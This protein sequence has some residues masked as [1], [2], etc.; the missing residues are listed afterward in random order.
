M[1]T[2]Q[3]E[4]ES[5]EVSDSSTISTLEESR[6]L[7]D[8]HNP[9]S[10]SDPLAEIQG[11]EETIDD[12]DYPLLK[13]E[14]EDYRIPPGFKPKID[15]DTT[16][17][18]S[19][20]YD[21]NRGV[22]IR[23]KDKALG[24]ELD[25][26]VQV[27]VLEY[28]EDQPDVHQNCVDKNKTD[29]MF[30]HIM[31]KLT[32][33][34]CKIN[35]HQSDTSK[36]ISEHMDQVKGALVENKAEVRSLLEETQRKIEHSHTQILS[37]LESHKTSVDNEL[38]AIN[39]NVDR[40][41]SNLTTDLEAHRSEV[42]KEFER[43]SA[44]FATDLNDHRAVVNKVLED[45][46]RTH[47]SNEELQANIIGTHNM[48]SNQIMTNN[49]YVQACMAEM[50]RKWA[51]RLDNLEKQWEDKLTQVKKET[52]LVKPSNAHNSICSE[53]EIPRKNL[54]NISNPQFEL[55]SF[56]PSSESTPMGG[57]PQKSQPQIVSQDVRNKN[58]KGTPKAINKGYT[59]CDNNSGSD[60]QSK[61]RN[62]QWIE[63]E[64]RHVN[65][66][67]PPPP[68]TNLPLQHNPN[69]PIQTLPQQNLQ[70][71]QNV[72]RAIN[73]GRPQQ[74]FAI[75]EGTTK[76][77]T[78]GGE[79]GENWPVFRAFFERKTLG[80]DEN[81]KL[82]LFA[83]CLMG[84]AAAFWIS[85]P[86]RIQTN[87]SLLL[88]KFNQKYEKVDDPSMTLQKLYIVKQKPNQ[89]VED[90][91]EEVRLLTQ[92]G[93]PQADQQT[94]DTLA[95]SQ[96]LSGARNKAA[97]LTV[98][99]SSPRTLDE[100]LK[101]YKKAVIYQQAILGNSDETPVDSE[102]KPIDVRRLTDT[103]TE[104]YS[105]GYGRSSRS[106]NRNSG[107]NGNYARSPRR[108]DRGSGQYSRS[109]NRETRDRDRQ[110][111]TRSPERRYPSPRRGD[112]SPRRERYEK[113]PRSRSPVVTKALE[114]I[115]DV[116]AKVLDNLVNQPRRNRS[117]S[118]DSNMGNMR[119]WECGKTG[120][121]QRDCDQISSDEEGKKVKF[122]PQRQSNEGGSGP[123][124]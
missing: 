117:P 7:D 80:I 100:A 41:R 71:I 97:C 119:C 90:F 109:P 103:R 83:D 29:S 23:R 19:I 87:Y 39:N 37:E 123:E 81:T 92:G 68:G 11:N 33:I 10:P 8:V 46:Q 12:S 78:F 60:N 18:S 76:L 42:N 113:D 55:E 31:S 124:A 111:Y 107:R 112:R 15:I 101:S 21:P 93:L 43:M 79:S 24:A 50:D 102:V 9:Q 30:A 56:L 77:R 70:N 1:E 115:N 34:D 36:T 6:P 106:P 59:S 4:R 22:T 96:F 88:E 51:S 98:C 62:N 47:S 89:D 17:D 64:N 82:G 65:T 61:V 48:I 57:I 40:M 86:N 72:P 25:Q 114:N 16:G 5:I 95:C 73:Q 94:W 45:V 122:R 49:T 99:N 108:D 13:K 116:L 105:G 44:S 85:L 54:S 3:C 120:H 66:S 38:G 91:A 20:S 67:V 2:P 28:S 14:G 35:A 53:P 27:D 75:G 74:T 118:P 32:M 121:F 84:K 58:Y 52:I 104:N 110:N 26:S 63:A 69:F